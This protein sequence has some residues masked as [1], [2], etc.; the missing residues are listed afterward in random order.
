MN[1]QLQTTNKRQGISKLI[2]TL[3]LASLVLGS[4]DV[5]AA[6]HRHSYRPPPRRAAP[7]WPVPPAPKML[8]VSAPLTSVDNLNKKLAIWDKQNGRTLFLFFTPQT[9]FT[10][11]GKSVKATEVKAGDQAAVRYQDTDFTV[12]EVKVTTKPSKRK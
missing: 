11:D 12:K 5:F 1:T 10:K 3:A 7:R 4:S 8:N 9:K 6:R 2:G